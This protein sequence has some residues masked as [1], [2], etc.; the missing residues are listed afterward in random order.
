MSS[1]PDSI[2]VQLTLDASTDSVR[3][4]RLL[5]SAVA[6]DAGFDVDDIDDLK[7]AID[8]ACVAV[9][10]GSTPSGSLTLS[11]VAA[12]EIVDVSGSCDI[13]GDFDEPDLTDTSL[14]S[15]I[16]RAVVDEVTFT[17]GDGLASFRMRKRR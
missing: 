6:D 14:Q 15:Q 4:A 2:S 8:E 1:G 5:A 17:S 12:G 16:L 11:F 10:E 3:Y 13:E 7:I 9:I